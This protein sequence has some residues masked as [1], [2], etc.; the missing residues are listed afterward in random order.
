MTANP[1]LPA[2]R[3][4]FTLTVI[5]AALGYFADIFDIVLFTMVRKPSMIEL[6][7]DPATQGTILLDWQLGG[8][9]LGGLVFGILGDLVGRRTAMFASIL[10]YSIANL[11]NACVGWFP[12]GDNLT[13][14]AALRFLSGFGLAGELGAAIALVSE[15]VPSRS[16]GYATTFVAA[17]GISGAVGAWVA[18]TYC[19]WRWAYVIGGLLGFAVLALRLR[20]MESSLFDRA[21]SSKVRRGDPLL[22]LRTS[23]RPFLLCTLIGLPLWF[24]VG[25]LVAESINVGKSLG[26]PGINPADCML[27]CYVG[28]V[29][30]DLASGLLSQWLRS[31]RLAIS[32]F[33]VLTGA[34]SFGYL[35]Q[36][37][38]SQ[39]AMNLWSIAL[40]LGCGYWALFVTI[41][42]EQ[43]ATNL[44]V[45]AATV[46]TNLVR[47]AVPLWTVVLGYIA[48]GGL[49][50][51]DAL[52]LLGGALVAIALVATW[53]LPESFGKELDYVER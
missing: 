28:L 9:L 24:V 49:G 14:Y 20:V 5:A 47:G 12:V 45:T 18:A 53:L 33:L 7:L 42:A 37:Q 2:W 34:L 40:G 21:V 35:A 52:R 25:K 51:L 48:V 36:Q 44:R 41:G 46:I 16:R 3:A 32:I 27:W 43:F 23:W 4:V 13:Q 30:G 6:G 15:S 22:L 29:A 11:A 50:H 38:P 1:S 10:T 39:F 26:S 19:P 8:M 17:L 31:R